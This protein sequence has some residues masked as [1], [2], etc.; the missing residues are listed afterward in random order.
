VSEENYLY[1]TNGVSK[2]Y[3][4]SVYIINKHVLFQNVMIMSVFREYLTGQEGTALECIEIEIWT[5]LPMPILKM[6]MLI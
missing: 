5:R 6:R 2:C 1:V 4:L 3:V